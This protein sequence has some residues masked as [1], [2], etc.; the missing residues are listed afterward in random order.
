[1]IMF[2]AESNLSDSWCCDVRLGV[3]SGESTPASCTCMRTGVS[4]SPRLVFVNSR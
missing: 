1:M 2:V 3:D 4:R